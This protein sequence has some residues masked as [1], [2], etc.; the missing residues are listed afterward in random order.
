MFDA[1]CDVFGVQK[2]SVRLE[3]FQPLPAMKDRFDLVCS[4]MPTFNAYA[5]G[6]PWAIDAWRFLLDDI[7]Q[8]VLTT[9]GG[10]FL[11]FANG[12][13]SDAIWEQMVSEAL[14]S[15]EPAHYIYIGNKL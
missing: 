10:I 13:I 9:D 5:N 6:K 14:W 4:F 12:R 8:N 1:L 2:I 11:Q 3:A 15:N 7:Q